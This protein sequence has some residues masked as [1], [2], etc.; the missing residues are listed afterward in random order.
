MEQQTA[1]TRE[2]AYDTRNNDQVKPVGHPP[3]MTRQPPC[4]R[5]RFTLPAHLVP[6]SRYQGTDSAI[7]YVAGFYC[8]STAAAAFVAAVVVLWLLCV[9]LIERTSVG[10]GYLVSG[11]KLKPFEHCCNSVWAEN[12]SI[13]SRLSPKRHCSSPITTAVEEGRV[14]FPSTLA[15]AGMPILRPRNEER[16]RINHP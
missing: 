6:L 11:L 15:G 13:L 12:S 8:R 16:G 1:D 10:V 4:T 7:L 3:L 5:H 9:R 14:V 2:L